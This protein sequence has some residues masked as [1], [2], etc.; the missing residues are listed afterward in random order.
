MRRSRTTATS[1]DILRKSTVWF[2]TSRKSII[3]P[4]GTSATTLFTIPRA[5]HTWITRLTWV[6][7]VTFGITLSVG[8]M[9]IEVR[10]GRTH[11]TASVS[12][13]WVLRISG[14]LSE[15]M[16]SVTSCSD[17]CISSVHG[18]ISSWCVTSVVCRILTRLSMQIFLSCLD[19]PSRS[20]LTTVRQTSKRQPTSF[21]PI[22]RVGMRHWLVCRH[23]RRMICVLTSSWLSATLASVIFM[24]ARHWWRSLRRPRTVA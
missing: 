4:H 5:M 21:L 1:R 15:P 18:G 9:A 14:R 19:S 11:G 7:I 10:F 16:R 24:L 12:A 23:Q 2:L 13:T 8:L 20:V 3:V 22:L 17:S 6:T